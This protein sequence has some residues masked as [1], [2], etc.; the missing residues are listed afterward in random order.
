M[1][2][3]SLWHVNAFILT[4]EAAMS[5]IVPVHQSPSRYAV[6]RVDRNFP[7]YIGA[8]LAVA[9]AGGFLLAIVLPLAAALEW[10][11]GTRW[12]ALVQAH[13]HLQVLGWAGLF[14]VGMATR[15]LPRFAG[16]PL[17]GGG[18]TGVM[19][20][21]LAGGM[22]GRSLAQPA[23]DV[24]GMRAVLLVSA[25]AE[26]AGTLL[27]LAML[28]ATLL[29]VIRT[30]PPAPLV[31][32]GAAALVVQALL[33]LLW[34]GEITTDAP[35]LTPDRNGALLTVQVYG[36]LIPFVLGVGLKALPV[37]FGRTA[38]DARWTTVLAA[39]VLLSVTLLAGGRLAIDT[40]A[41]VR[42]EAIG[43]LVLGVTLLAGLAWTGAWQ[44][45]ARLRPAARR[46]ALLLQTA[47]A[48]LL[49]A[50][51][52]LLWMGVRSV[53][54][55]LPG[56]A[57]QADAVRHLVLVGTVTTLIVGMGQL[58]LPWLAMRRPHQRGAG[59]EHWVLWSLLTSATALRVTGALLE[60]A[61]AGS[62]RYSV[63]TAAGV[64]GIVAVSLF[65]LSILRAARYR[66]ATVELS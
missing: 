54:S 16:R 55:G 51:L 45:P 52:G 17:R 57:Y 46:T 9:V 32:V 30:V 40:P 34:L 50:A 15:L 66:A 11:W 62:V 64:C 41:G 63:M 1:T 18:L 44:A 29:P 56:P 33:G 53:E 20:F 47:C 48:W 4:Y 58:V 19:L 22:L 38:P 6:A 65:A 28:A 49:L 2:L 42:L 25:S 8:A 35:Y 36:F 39:A 60:G 27:F 23:L 43:E 7:W 61:G 12:R 59:L 13:G 3:R 10:D 5:T 31:L 21:L 14:V 24:P 26:L 37:F